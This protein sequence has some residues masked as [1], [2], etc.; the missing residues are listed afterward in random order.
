MEDMRE[1]KQ[2]TQ[3]VAL[4]EQCPY[5]RNVLDYFEI[6]EY[7]GMLCISIIM[8]VSDFDRNRV[9]N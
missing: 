6:F 8:S 1:N 7:F 2:T 9:R 3:L 5:K 4:E